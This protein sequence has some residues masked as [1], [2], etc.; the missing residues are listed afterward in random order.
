MNP[1]L[2]PATTHSYLSL[3]AESLQEAITKARAGNLPL[4][5]AEKDSFIT[6]ISE[7]VPEAIKMVEN[8]RVISQQGGK[9]HGNAG[10]YDHSGL[11]IHKCEGYPVK[12]PHKQVH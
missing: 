12:R 10:G 9:C 11:P 7:D 2:L 1:Y 6:I 8:F 3:S 5:H 4:E